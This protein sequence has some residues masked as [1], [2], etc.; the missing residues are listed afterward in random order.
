MLNFNENG[1]CFSKVSFHESPIR[2]PKRF[3]RSHRMSGRFVPN[4]EA[5]LIFFVTI[6]QSR[7]D[8]LF[9]AVPFAIDPPYKYKAGMWSVMIAFFIAFLLYINSTYSPRSATLVAE[10]SLDQHSGQKDRMC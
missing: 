2:L 3:F 1:V 10:T 6:T 4:W 9:K 7:S 5:S 8:L